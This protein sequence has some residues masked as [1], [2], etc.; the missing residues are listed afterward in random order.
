MSFYPVTRSTLVRRFAAKK[1]GEAGAAIHDLLAT[2]E[3]EEWPDDPAGSSLILSSLSARRR[4]IRL[5]RV[6]D[7]LEWIERGS[8]RR[9]DVA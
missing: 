4:G 6:G 8:T 7:K 1:H 2:G 3:V 9:R 5:E